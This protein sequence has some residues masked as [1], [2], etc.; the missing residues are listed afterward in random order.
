MHLA[1][2]GKEG[3]NDGLASGHLERLEGELGA[4]SQVALANGLKRFLSN[5]F[6][7]LY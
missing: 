6:A 4:G 3:L 2:A 5:D 7:C 1:L